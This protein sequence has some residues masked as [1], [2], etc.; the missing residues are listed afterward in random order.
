MGVRSER[1]RLRG[2]LA[3]ALALS[4]VGIYF[5]LGEGDPAPSLSSRPPVSGAV[6]D[7]DKDKLEIIQISPGEPSPG[8]AIEIDL[9]EAKTK[10][11]GR[12]GRLRANISITDFDSGKQFKRDL[13]ILHESDGRL[14]ARVPRDAM[15][16]RA[17]LRVFAEA[18]SKDAKEIRSKPYDLRV[19]PVNTRKFFR[20]MVGGLALLVFGMR[21]MSRGTR[22]YT[23]QRSQGVLARIGRRRAAA[24]GLGVV[25]GGIT[26][27]TT[28]AAG[29]VVG[30]VESHLLA[31]IPAVAILLGSHLGAALPSILGILGLASTKEG[32]L[33]VT[34]GV[35]FLGLASDRRSEA[36]GKVV[37]GAGLLFYGLN[38]LRQGFEPL[39]ANPEIFP[40]LDLFHSETLTGRLTCVL[41][42]VLLTAILQGPTPVFI[43]ILGLAQ[44]T[45]RIDLT[46]ALAILSGSGVG[47]AVGTMA[48]AWPFSAG[49]RRVG[50]LHL[51]VA[52][53]GTVALIGSV[54]VWARMSEFLVSG[55]ASEI[56]YGKKI[57]LPRFGRHLGVAYGLSQVVL[58]ILS[59]L[60]IPVFEKL[61]NRWEGD[62]GR[63]FLPLDGVAGV[64]ALRAGL[65]DVLS[66]HRQALLNIHELCLTGHRG[67]GSRS[68]HVL[69]DARHQIEGLFGGA[70]R[71]RSA[72]P[73]MFRLRQAAL[74]MVQLHRAIEDLLR[75][76]EKSTEQHLVLSPA[77]EAWQLAPRE[78]QTLKS[79]HALLIEGVDTLASRLQTGE[80]PDVDEARA[81]EIRLNAVEMD[82]RQGLLSDADKGEKSGLI[83]LR[84]NASELVNAYE[85]VGNHLYRLY[86]TLGADVDQETPDGADEGVGL[87]GA[88]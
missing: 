29:L 7:E 87:S 34:M 46:S 79:L 45:G 50:R 47:A 62:R 43:L 73:E 13:E 84:L 19:R 26:Q 33:V 76:A 20:E 60:A 14:I 24:V 3:W 70:V 49:A 37:L 38:L 56:E 54:D 77:G 59:V 64:R 63:R 39:L 35:L 53:V 57:L 86:E 4:L 1:R 28:T 2:F 52:L 61:L 67:Q 55:N 82:S 6:P 30:L 68:E 75:A 25:V 66:R 72:E 71:V 42:G 81:R 23:G 88:I 5:A 31:T 22:Q 12:K 40:Y 15:V 8:S 65:Q 41:A 74:A 21:V 36:F 16:G 18:E 83:T 9:F 27:F 80:A 78:E 48:V 58:T 51:A 32:L 85:S 11:E 10:G 17:K 69:T 44:S